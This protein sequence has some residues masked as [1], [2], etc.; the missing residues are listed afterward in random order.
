MRLAAPAQTPEIG[1]LS[2]PASEP[3]NPT[4][5]NPPKDARNWATPALRL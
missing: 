3:V 1:F 5:K 2:S 4:L